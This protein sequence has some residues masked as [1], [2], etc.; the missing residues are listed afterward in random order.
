M[1][2]LICKDG[3]LVTYF[4]TIDEIQ[5]GFKGS[6]LNQILMDNQEEVAKIGNVKGHLT[7]RTYFLILE[8]F[9]KNP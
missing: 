5:S 9:R 4:E 8:N 3:N 2:L 6:S 1:R 7:L